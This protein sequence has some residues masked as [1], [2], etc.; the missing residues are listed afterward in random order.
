MASERRLKYRPFAS[1]TITV[2]SPSSASD[3]LGAGYKPDYLAFT[4]TSCLLLAEASARTS[5]VERRD[6]VPE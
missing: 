4:K 2:R 6:L 3:C 1:C 5:V